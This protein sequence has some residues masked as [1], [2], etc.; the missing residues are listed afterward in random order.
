MAACGPEAGLGLKPAEAHE[1]SPGASDLVL[2]QAQDHRL[3][4]VSSIK[5]A[6]QVKLARDVK[7]EE[8]L[9]RG[10]EDEDGV[11][12][13]PAGEGKSVDHIALALLGRR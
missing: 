7:E 10:T 8:L 9:G 2:A 4:E 3:F 13:E 6:P 5:R 11:L 1:V 12:H